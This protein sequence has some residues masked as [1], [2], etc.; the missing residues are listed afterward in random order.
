[1]S[2]VLLTV[3][4]KSLAHLRAIH[5]TVGAP[6]DWGYDTA[7]G[8]ALYA[9]Y[10]FER[11]LVAAIKAAKTDPTDA[12]PGLVAALQTIVVECMAYPPVKPQSGDS[13]IPRDM[14]EAAQAALA[15]AKG[16]AS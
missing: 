15:K 16:D 9:F 3:S 1:M 5:K 14:V 12:M 8:Q 4:E 2:A 7:M 6:G 10:Q 13:Y 11:E